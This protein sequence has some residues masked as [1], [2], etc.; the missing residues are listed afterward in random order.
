M[1][2]SVQCVCWAMPHYASPPH[3]EHRGLSLFLCL[4]AAL[5][6]L[7][8]LLQCRFRHRG[9]RPR[10]V[11]TPPPQQGAL[12]GVG[13][14]VQ[15]GQ[16]Q[17]LW[18][19]QGVVFEGLQ[20]GDQDGGPL[21]LGAA[22]AAVAVPGEQARQARD[23]VQVGLV[24]AQ[25]GQ[26]AELSQRGQL[27]EPAGPCRKRERKGEESVCSGEYNRLTFNEVSSV[28]FFLVGDYIVCLDSNAVCVTHKAPSSTLP[29]LPI[30]FLCPLK[31]PSQRDECN[32]GSQLL[33]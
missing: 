18:G 19:L 14:R 16:D 23:G 12:L 17:A 10:L 30:V 26:R 9:L 13:A 32:C 11:R 28:D 7:L 22:G 5:K 31:Q 29:W 24:G 33:C 27:G 25:P 8:H 4:P 1:P 6:A 2:L 20:R 21:P 3:R 15:V